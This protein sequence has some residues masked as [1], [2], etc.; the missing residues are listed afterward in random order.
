MIRSTGKKLTEAP[1]IPSF[2]KTIS[3]VVNPLIQRSKVAEQFNLFQKSF[4]ALATSDTFDQLKSQT[5]AIDI[6]DEI[7]NMNDESALEI[8]VP[9]L[10]ITDLLGQSMWSETI[11]QFP[12]ILGINGYA[13]KS[14]DIEDNNFPRP[15]FVLI[16]DIAGNQYEAVVNPDGTTDLP[17]DGTGL[18][19]IPSRITFIFSAA[20]VKHGSGLQKLPAQAMHAQ[21]MYLLPPEESNE[22]FELHVC[23]THIDK[24]NGRKVDS[25]RSVEI[26]YRDFSFENIHFEP[27]VKRESTES[28]EMNLG[29]ILLSAFIARQPFTA[30]VAF[31]A[32][33]G[34]EYSFHHPSHHDAHQHGWMQHPIFPNTFTKHFGLSEAT[35]SEMVKELYSEQDFMNGHLA[36]DHFGLSYQQGYNNFLLRPE[37]LGHF[38]DLMVHDL[39]AQKIPGEFLFDRIAPEIL[40]E[41]DLAHLSA[42]FHDSIVLSQLQ[43]EQTGHHWNSFH[44]LFLSDKGTPMDRGEHFSVYALGL[45][46][47]LP[48]V[49]VEV[50]PSLPMLE[51]FEHNDAIMSTHEGTGKTIHL[52][53]IMDV[54]HLHAHPVDKLAGAFEQRS[55]LPSYSLTV[56]GHASGKDA[57]TWVDP[58][59]VID[60][61]IDL[62]HIPPPEF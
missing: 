11:A 59:P 23:V 31:E 52:G 43:T 57:A 29:I 13:A 42:N 25:I 51:F 2:Y 50:K 3:Y 8:T 58:H 62:N 21:K 7:A 16:T 30:A 37:A 38:Y 55:F 54:D 32:K 26:N 45:D 18:F 24:R 40:A 46:H 12:R 34:V 5:I 1:I 10:G 36:G 48:K 19:S 49:T 47:G 6:S 20:Q 44:Q 41:I 22:P 17:Q 14:S 28:V 9:V 39:V 27:Q 56:E 4:A 35:L 60:A 61:P 53:E 33:P 15:E